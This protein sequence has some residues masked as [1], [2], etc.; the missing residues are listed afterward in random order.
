M[1]FLRV[2]V[3][4]LQILQMHIKLMALK[5]AWYK[6]P[7]TG[8]VLPRCRIKSDVLLWLSL[9]NFVRA[10][11]WNR[12]YH[13]L[14]IVHL[15]PCKTQHLW[16]PTVHC[17]YYAMQCG[18]NNGAVFLLLKMIWLSHQTIISILTISYLHCCYFSVKLKHMVIN[19]LTDL[20][21]SKVAFSLTCTLGWTCQNKHLFLLFSKLNTE[22]ADKE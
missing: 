16:N 18:N 11:G 13:S 1:L 9:P 10:A 6:T 14:L 19:W 7:L 22:V 3:Y 20:D 2:T 5:M 15:L 17:C 8:K 4:Q 21:E 12:M